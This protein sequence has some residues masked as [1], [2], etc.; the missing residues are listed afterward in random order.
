MGWQVEIHMGNLTALPS[1]PCFLAQEM[2]AQ[3]RSFL[4]R[5]SIIYQMYLCSVTRV[6]DINPWALPPGMLLGKLYSRDPLTHQRWRAE[7]DFLLRLFFHTARR[8]RI[9]LQ[10]RDNRL[11]IPVYAKLINLL[12]NFHLLKLLSGSSDLLLLVWGEVF[13]S[14]F[15]VFPLY[16][17]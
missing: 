7:I 6:A 10:C 13:R 8:L 4:Y 17:D 15:F 16:R 12:K 9:S 1:P 5:A 3:W 11:L 2:W 14:L